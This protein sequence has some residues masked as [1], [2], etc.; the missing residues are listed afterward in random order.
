[1]KYHFITTKKFDE[2]KEKN[3]L[4]WVFAKEPQIRN[5]LIKILDLFCAGDY[6][7]CRNLMNSLE[8]DKKHFCH[9]KDYVPEFVYD[10]LLELG[11][12]QQIIRDGGWVFLPTE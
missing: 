10:S 5:K 3:L 4:N 12:N 1:M 7:E 11:K 6:E 9:Q 2:K 8:Y